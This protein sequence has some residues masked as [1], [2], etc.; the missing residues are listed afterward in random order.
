[1]RHSFARPFKQ[2]LDGMYD[3]TC[4]CIFLKSL[5]NETITIHIKVPFLFFNLLYQV[6]EPECF[7]ISIVGVAVWRVAGVAANPATSHTPCPSQLVCPSS[8]I[9]IEACLCNGLECNDVLPGFCAL[10]AGTNPGT[11]KDENRTSSEWKHTW[12][13]FS[14]HRKKVIH[15]VM[16]VFD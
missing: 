4:T 13:Q 12:M 10:L 1:M 14:R 5:K 8:Y 9:S 6:P 3:Y 2:Q 11:K 15:F 16:V 7:F